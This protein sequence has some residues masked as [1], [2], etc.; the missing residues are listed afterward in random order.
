[1]SYFDINLDGKIQASQISTQIFDESENE[2]I[3]RVQRRLNGP[4]PVYYESDLPTV[5]ID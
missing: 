4:P 5:E 2:F 3:M 1:M